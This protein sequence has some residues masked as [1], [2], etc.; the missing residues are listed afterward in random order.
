MVKPVTDELPG[1]ILELIELE[2][3]ELIICHAGQSDQP[4]MKINFS[5][6]LKDNL[7]E[8]YLNVAKAM[9]TAGIQ[10]VAESGLELLSSNS[11][12]EN[13]IILH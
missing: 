1:L 10:E 8:Q 2:S 11:E 6:K 9:L 12:Q 4:I 7:K 5:E 13:K 3:G